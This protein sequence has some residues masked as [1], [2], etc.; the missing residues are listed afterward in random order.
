MTP[1]TRSNREHSFDWELAVIV[2]LEK[3]ILL[4]NI[5]YW[6]EENRRRAALEYFQHGT[7]WTRESLK[8]LARKYPYFTMPSISRWMN[9][10]CAAGW[11]RMFG[12]S[13][14]TN[15]YAPG[16][17]F[18]AWNLGEDWKALTSSDLRIPS[19]NEN[20]IDLLKTRTPVSQNE[21]VGVLKM[22]NRGSQNEKHEY[23]NVD[24]Q[25]DTDVECAARARK[26]RPAS[27]VA[28]PP[29]RRNRDTLMPSSGPAPRPTTFANSIW[30]TE[31]PEAWRVALT[32]ETNI[33]DL[34]AAWYFHRCKDWS[35]EKGSTSANWVVT[36][37]K[38]ARD[39]QRK[40]KLV[41]LQPIS[42][43]HYSAIPNPGSSRPGKPGFTLHTSRQ[44]VI[45][46]AE[47]VLAKRSARYG[48]R[49]A[50]V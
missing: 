24:Y 19:Q 27:D 26:P 42:N 47:R 43:D 46:V 6:C 18:D 39:D 32:T 31:T 44:D 34:D 11:V 40:Q 33:P 15:F 12:Q 50:D 30:S 2:G 28:S 10:L 29:Q 8:T 3:A 48:G 4:K 22:R 1:I 16:A 9:Q 14:G 17:A 45:D 38:F 41:T 5:S 37:A 35:A 25:I 20:P 21:K 13:G 7:W 36:A 49:V 23:S